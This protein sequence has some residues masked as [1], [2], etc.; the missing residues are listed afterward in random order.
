MCCGSSNVLKVVKDHEFSTHAKSSEK[1]TLPLL[2]CEP[3]IFAKE[4]PDGKK[5]KY[6]LHIKMTL[7]EYQE[8]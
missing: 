4:N 1:L 5:N 8:K 3:W 7:P 6:G 2:P